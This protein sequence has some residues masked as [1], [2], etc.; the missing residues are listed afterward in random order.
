MAGNMRVAGEERGGKEGE[1]E[2]GEKRWRMEGGE[3][4]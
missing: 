2:E 4:E 1:R 3:G